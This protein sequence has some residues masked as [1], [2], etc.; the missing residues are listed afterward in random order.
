[1]GVQQRL[2]RFGIISLFFVLFGT[3][4]TVGKE[5]KPTFTLRN[6]QLNLYIEALQ[7]SRKTEKLKSI[8]EKEIPRTKNIALLTKYTRIA[9]EEDFLKISESGLNY[10]YKLSPND[11]VVMKN[12]GILIAML[13][14]V[15][16]LMSLKK[17]KLDEPNCLCMCVCVRA[18]FSR[19]PYL[20]NQ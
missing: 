17:L 14:F 13:F 12:L 11:Y 19:H 1:M 4:Q 6:Q 15:F 16:S 20:R 2:F 5:Q 9:V 8:L 7:L 10:L 3:S 18:S